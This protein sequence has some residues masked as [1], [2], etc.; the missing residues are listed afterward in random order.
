MFNLLLFKFIVFLLVYKLCNE[1]R[2]F[3]IYYLKRL[4]QCKI[5]ILSKKYP[6]NKKNKETPIDPGITPRKTKEIVSQNNTIFIKE[7]ILML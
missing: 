6:I 1:L 2:Y 7:K 3:R 5:R 4:H